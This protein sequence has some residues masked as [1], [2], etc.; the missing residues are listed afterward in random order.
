LLELEA[1]STEE[2]KITLDSIRQ[3]MDKIV[4]HGKRA[5]SIIKGM[6]LHS[7]NG[8][9]EKQLTD[10]NT[11]AA[12]IFQLAYHGMRTQEPGFHCTLTERL[13]AALPM[14]SWYQD[15]SRAGTC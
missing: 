2:Q 15:I 14:V 5:D 6:L 3:N 8:T 12:E 1:I 4:F 13:D 9:H 7:R 11:L 10:M